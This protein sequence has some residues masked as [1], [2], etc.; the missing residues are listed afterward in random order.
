[1]NMGKSGELSSLDDVVSKVTYL[2]SHITIHKTEKFDTSRAWGCLSPQ[3]N[4]Y[5]NPEDELTQSEFTELAK[6]VAE[7]VNDWEWSYEEYADKGKKDV[8]DGILSETE[9]EDQTCPCCDDEH[10]VGDNIGLYDVRKEKVKDEE[11]ERRLPWSSTLESEQADYIDWVTEHEYN[12]NQV[13]LSDLETLIRE[14]QG[15]PVDVELDS[16]NLPP[17][18][19]PVWNMFDDGSG[20]WRDLDRDLTFMPTP[21]TTGNLVLSYGEYKTRVL[22]DFHAHSDLI[23]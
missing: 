9:L 5:F 14:W 11:S 13:T 12:G 6:E 18:V 1:M 17:N 20:D 4:D 8:T 19:L 16:Y 21:T 23:E 2:I 15:D 22:M 7:A 10:P 3:S